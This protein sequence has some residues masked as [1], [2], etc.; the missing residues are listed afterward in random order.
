MLTLTLDDE[1]SAALEVSNHSGVLALFAV[2]HILDNQLVG[3]LLRQ[4][5]VV[6]I[7]L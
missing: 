6:L 1:A 5:S 3:L 2:V 7:R 4:H